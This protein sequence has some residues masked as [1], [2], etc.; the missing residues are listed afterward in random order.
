MGFIGP[1]SPR[2][3]EFATRT[4][5]LLVKY[6]WVWKDKNDAIP[7]RAEYVAIQDDIEPGSSLAFTYRPPHSLPDR[8][9]GYFVSSIEIVGF[10]PYK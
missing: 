8:D 3:C 2:N 10:T 1:R 7:A 6:A 5:E 9:D 4:V